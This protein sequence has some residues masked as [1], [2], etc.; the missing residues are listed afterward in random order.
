ML[1]SIQSCFELSIHF[2]VF[3]SRELFFSSSSRLV[4]FIDKCKDMSKRNYVLSSTATF[5]SY[6]L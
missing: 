4:C 5:L 3:F 6:F 1:E 2:P